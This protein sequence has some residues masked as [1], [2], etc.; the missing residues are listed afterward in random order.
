VWAILGKYSTLLG[1]QMLC[2]YKKSNE[3]WRMCT[4]LNKACPNDSY[5]LPNIEMLVDGVVGCEMLSFMDAY[6]DYN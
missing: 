6:L 4:D 2:W 5:L 3:K 1:L